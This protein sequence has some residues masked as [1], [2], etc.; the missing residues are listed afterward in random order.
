MT[1]S[2]R[3]LWLVLGLAFLAHVPLHGAT[4]PPVP[5]RTVSPRYPYDMQE[6][7]ISGVVWV[8]FEVDTKGRVENAK[9]VKA[10]RKEFEQAA[11][12][13]VRHWAFRPGTENGSPKA[14]TVQIPLRFDADNN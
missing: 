1:R 2:L 12:D 13:A 6:E 7:H 14:M 10:T 5:V 3:P 11:V 9:V 8:Q 4:T